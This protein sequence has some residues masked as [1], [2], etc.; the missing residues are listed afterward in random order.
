[1]SKAKHLVVEHLEDISWIVLRDY[2]QVVKEMIRGYSGIYAL[3]RRN[4]LYYVGLA[5][6]LMSRLDQHL[7]DKHKGKWDR[8][9]VYLT[10]HNEHMKELE[11]L[12]LR[13]VSPSGNTVSGKLPKS[14]NQRRALNQL[15]KGHDD[16]RRAALI[17]GAYAV[18]HRKKMIASKTK[19]QPVLAGVVP[20]GIALRAWRNGWEYRAS[21]RKDGLIRFGENTYTSPSAAGKAAT[22]KACNG[23]RFWH[24]RDPKLGDWVP[25]NKLKK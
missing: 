1:M 15:I 10:V 9:S 7:K 19:G 2:R 11:S 5:S 13:I 21:L 4:K 16:D 23:W 20:R 25:L 17:G 8:F 18:K 12:V 6:N 24:Y 22:N 14:A 3:Y